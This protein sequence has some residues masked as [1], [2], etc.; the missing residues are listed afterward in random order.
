MIG[1]TQTSPA[2][3]LTTLVVPVAVYFLVI[4][5][6]NTRKTPQ[7][8]SGRQ[9]FALLFLAICPL[10][11]LPALEWAGMTPISLLI[12]A[13]ALAGAIWILAPR[14]RCWVIYNLDQQSA[15]RTVGRIFQ[16]MG[17][18]ADPD[19]HDNCRATFSGFAFMRNVSVHLHDASP[20]QARQFEQ[21]LG[22]RLGRTRAE[23]NPLAAGMLMVATAMLVAPITFLAHQ[24]A[25][26]LA[27]L[28]GDLLK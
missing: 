2:I 1:L 12:A 14:D 10:F 3:Q 8:L 16:D 23:H 11:V 22:H 13:G 28:I 24:S 6:L 20:E 18:Q 4:G 27:R 25:P 26:Q 17:L 19:Q 9:D 7:I 21:H 15:R 5:L